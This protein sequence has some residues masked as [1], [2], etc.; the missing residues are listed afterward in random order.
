MWHVTW[1]P[2]NAGALN[3]SVWYHQPLH[4]HV[5]SHFKSWCIFLIL[6]STFPSASTVL[7]I[8]KT[9]CRFTCNCHRG[10][11]QCGGG[12]DWWK[13]Q[14]N[15]ILTQETALFYV[16]NIK[17]MVTYFKLHNMHFCQS[18][19]NCKPFTMLRICLLL[20]LR[21][22]Y[23]S[24]NTKTPLNSSIYCYLKWSTAC[25]FKWYFLSFCR[26]ESK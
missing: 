12:C 6:V 14:T 8:G 10:E 3:C 1:L 18:Q 7:Y 4:H 15:R 25:S 13:G 24:C 23:Y 22:Q 20:L 26:D 9:A 16:W 5:L 17:S 21:Q 11:N 2:T 19:P